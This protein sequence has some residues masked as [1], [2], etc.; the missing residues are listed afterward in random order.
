M[1]GPAATWSAAAA[2][3]ESMIIVEQCES[4][5]IVEQCESMMLGPAAI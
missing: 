3:G 2:Q 5:I 4:M 1:L